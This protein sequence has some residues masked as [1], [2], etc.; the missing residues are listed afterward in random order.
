MFTSRL[1]F[2]LFLIYLKNNFYK[3]VSGCWNTSAVLRNKSFHVSHPVR[4]PKP[5]PR[6]KSR[7]PV[8]GGKRWIARLLANSKLI[9]RIDF[10]R[11]RQDVIMFS[12]LCWKQAGLG[13]WVVLAVMMRSCCCKNLGGDVLSGDS[14]NWKKF[15]IHGKQFIIFSVLIILGCTSSR[16]K[17][18]SW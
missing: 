13:W 9:M 3:C 10:C 12:W 14:V 6:C 11:F 15:S 18:G 1:P 5:E 7:L 4:F 17:S 2:G 8:I 16:K